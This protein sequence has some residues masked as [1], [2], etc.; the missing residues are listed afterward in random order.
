[1]NAEKLKIHESIDISDAMNLLFDFNL[2]VSP[3]F[4]SS[5]IYFII[6]AVFGC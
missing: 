1:M 5:N 4:S 6:G 3:V 2:D